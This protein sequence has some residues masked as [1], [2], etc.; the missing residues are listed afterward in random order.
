MHFVVLAWVARQMSP[1]E[2]RIFSLE[3][4]SSAV[5]YL[6]SALGQ[7]PEV[8][9]IFASNLLGWIAYST[10]SEEVNAPH[11]FKVSVAMLMYLLH[12]Q[13]WIKRRLSDTLLTFGP[14]IIDCANA[15]TT[16]H[17][18]VPPRGTRFEQRAKYFNEFRSFDNSRMWYSGILEAANATLGNLMEVSLSCVYQLVKREKDYDFTRDTV[19]TVLQYVRAELGDVDLHNALQAIDQSFKG[20]QVNH[21]TVEGQLITRLFHR[22]RCVLLLI[23]IL[24]QDSIQHGVTTPEVRYLA[25]IL[26]SCCRSQAIRRGGPIEDYYLIS[27]HNYSHLLLG[28][29][30]LQPQECPERK[31]PLGRILIY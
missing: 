31:F 28:G 19:D 24:E 11:H 3:Y 17:G 26:V 22:A 13:Q 18:I 8:Y 2:Y 6:N 23:T 12:G 7:T 25:K 5:S 10:C 9:D 21:T 30:A 27:W 14:F 1:S 20:G 15:W 29:M 4:I 16:R